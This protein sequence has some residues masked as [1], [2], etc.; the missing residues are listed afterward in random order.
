MLVLLRAYGV[1]GWC[2][3]NLE[4]GIVRPI[5]IRVDAQAEEML[6]VMGVNAGVYLISPAMGVFIRVHAKGIQDAS[7]LNLQLNRA[8]LVEIP[9]DTIFIVRG[10]KDV[11]DD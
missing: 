5:D 4:D 9:V 3:I 2:R 10:R 11:R 8:V 7:Q 6:V 1:L